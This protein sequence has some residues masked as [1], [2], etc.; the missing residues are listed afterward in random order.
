MRILMIDHFEGSEAG[1]VGRALVDAGAVIDRRAPYRGEPLPTDADGHDALVSFGGPQNALDDARFPYLAPLAAL[2]AQFGAANKA[3]LG[4]CLGSQ[5]IARGHGATNILGRPIEFGWRE[6]RPTAEGR[7]DPVISALG[8]GAPVFHWH[9]DTFTLPP[10]AAHLASSDHTAT[11]AFRIGRA[12]YGIQFHFEA[13]TAIVTDWSTAFPEIVETAH[14]GWLDA[15]PVLSQS[16]GRQAEQVGR[17]L[18]D[19]FIARVFA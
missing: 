16:L 3:V 8:D 15:L 18:A 19:G 14:P 7:A 9:S 11:Q 17:R 12:V 6:V 4:I 2:T 1:I 5:V 10:G 13:D